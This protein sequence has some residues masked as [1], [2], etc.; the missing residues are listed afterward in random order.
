VTCAFSKSFNHG[1]QVPS[2][3]QP[4]VELRPERFMKKDTIGIR[5]PAELKGTYANCQDGG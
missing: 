1:A 5:V 4:A 3:K 2:S